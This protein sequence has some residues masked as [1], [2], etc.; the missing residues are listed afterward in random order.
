MRTYSIK[1]GHTPD[2]TK[3]LK[4]YFDTE[5]D[6]DKGFEFVA[7]GIGSV[8][9]KKERNVLF[10]ETRALPGTKAEYAIIKKWNDFLFEVTGRTAKER[11]KLWD[12]E[13]KKGN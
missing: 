10:I 1:R 2:M 3:L 13:M 12:K 7:K 9:I 8:N 5:G 11:K 6:V 4:K